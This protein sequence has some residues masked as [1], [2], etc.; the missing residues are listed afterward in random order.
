MLRNCAHH[1]LLT[2]R[3][4]PTL[5]QLRFLP[6]RQQSEQPPPPRSS[7]NPS[8]SQ[9]H[10]WSPPSLLRVGLLYLPSRFSSGLL[11]AAATTVQLYGN[12]IR[13]RSRIARNYERKAA[14]PESASRWLCWKASPGSFH[15]KERGSP[16][17]AFLFRLANA[18]LKPFPEAP[19]MLSN[20][21]VTLVFG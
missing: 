16:L 13:R 20:Q 5:R 7:I 12:Q 6:S 10:T 3:P 21:Q 4:S 19:V 17:P 11:S 14:R 1:I 15:C 2:H 8:L 18:C 9:K